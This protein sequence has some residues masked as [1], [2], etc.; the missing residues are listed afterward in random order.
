MKKNLI[1]II[2]ANLAYMILVAG[3]NFILPRFTSYETYA[4]VKEYT[5]Y[6]TTFAELLT[7]GYIQGMYIKYGGKDLIEISPSDLGENFLSY[8]IFQ[9]PIALVV[10]IVGI[11]LKSYPIALLGVGIFVNNIV[12]YFQ[13]LYQAKK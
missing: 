4:A 2:L 11:V 3:T 9:L 10:T 1:R 13:M 12:K 6:I 8:T 5:L 7:F